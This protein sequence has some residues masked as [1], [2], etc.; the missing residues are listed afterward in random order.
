MGRREIHTVQ[1]IINVPI[2]QVWSLASSFGAIKAWMPS[3]KSVTI[4]GNGVGAVR[5]VGSMAGLV[6]EKLEVLDPSN[7]V[8]SYR[9]VDPTP[10]PAKGGFGTWK[11]ESIGEN[12]T[13]VTWIADAEEIDDAGI[14]FIKPIYEGFMADSLAGFVKA[15]S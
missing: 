15:L 13:K 11:L 4:E 1:E 9:I 12:K 14:A 5:T 2:E 3:I 10:L 6:Q 8:I 7:H